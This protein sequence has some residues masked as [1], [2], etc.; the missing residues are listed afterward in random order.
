M[1]RINLLEAWE[2]EKA[3]NKLFLRAFTFA[4]H[5]AAQDT[6]SESPLLDV[7]LGRPKNTNRRYSR[8]RRRS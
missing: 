7:V 2:S 5:R 1:I 4:Y 3:L 8:H 6:M